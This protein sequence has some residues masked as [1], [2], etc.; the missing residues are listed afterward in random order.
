MG[1][2]N[3]IGPYCVLTGKVTIGSRNKFLSHVRIGSPP[4]HRGFELVSGIEQS[5][6]SIQI[7]SNNTFFEFVS[8]NQP[9]NELTKIGSNGYFMAGV[10]IPHD[11]LIGDWV[12]IA[13][14]CSIGGHSNLL[15]GC[16]LGFQVAVHQFCTIGAFAMVGMGSIVLRDV[17]PF[18]KYIGVGPR[19]I[20]MNHIGLQRAGFDEEELNAALS[21]LESGVFSSPTHS[22]IAHLINDYTTTSQRPP[23]SKN[24]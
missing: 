23:S 24:E 21:W 1:S 6:G 17:P 3:Y 16:N 20:G 10:Y 22:R 14:G 12:T 7:G 9:F 15:E 18:G 19:K 5:S 13:N 2:G 4:E 11:C 8:V